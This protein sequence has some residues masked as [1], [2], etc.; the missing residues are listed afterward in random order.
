MQTKYGFQLMDIDEFS[1]WIAAQTVSREIN[2]IQQHHTYLPDYNHFTGSNH[3]ERM[4]S[5]KTY[6]TVNNGW[7]D[8]AQHF[9]TFP[10]GTI[11]ICR[12]LNQI[13][14]GIKGANARGICIEHFGNFDAGHDDMSPGHRKTIVELT[15]LLCRKFS[16]PPDTGHIVYH[17][18][19]DL[20]S[21]IR[22]DGKGTTKSCPGTAFFGGNKV[23]DA[24]REFIPLVKAAIQNGHFTTDIVQPGAA[25]AEVYETGIVNAPRLNVRLGPG[26]NYAVVSSL[27]TGA[28][29]AVYESKNGWLRISSENYWVA[30]RH[31]L[32][33]KRART[34]AGILNIRTGPGGTFNK[35]G[36]LPRNT[37]VFV[38]DTS[39]GWCRIDLNDK[40]VSS[41]Y[42]TY[43]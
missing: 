17:H 4:R 20:N 36:S 19:F 2:L 43:N 12:P 27:G 21:G 31:V 3:F 38:Y 39:P 9:T 22:R 25:S 23:A 16:L 5:M 42:L 1:G 8:I 10:D 15:A 11:G 30:E 13:P 41:A 32:K 14:V 35:I 29:V 6:H 40:W 26:T 24:E 37:S 7:S 33:V 34:T 28:V 18:W